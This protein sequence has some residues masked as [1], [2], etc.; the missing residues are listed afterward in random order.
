M[1]KPRPFIFP[2]FAILMLSSTLLITLLFLLTNGLQAAPNAIW[3]VNTFTG[4][5]GFDCTTSG[6]ACQTI[7]AAVDKAGNGDTIQIATGTYSEN[8]IWI[9]ET[10]TLNGAGVGNTIVDGGGNGRIFRISNETTLSGMTI[11]NGN[12]ITVGAIF[13][14]GGGAIQT[15]N[16]LTIQNSRIISNGTVG[17]GGGIFNSGTLILDNTDVLS[18]SSGLSG[19]GIYNSFLGS[20]TITNSVVGWN[21]SNSNPA[22]GGIYTTRPLYLTDVTLRDNRAPA[23][24]GGGLYLGDSGVA[25]DVI[26]TNVTFMGNQAN[27][28]A[29][30]SAQRGTITM[31]SGTVSG[32]VA[33][34][35]RGGIHLTGVDTSLNLINSTVVNNR[36]TGTTSAGYNGVYAV[37]GATATVSNSIIANNAENN[38]NSD[39]NFVSGGYNLADDDSCPFGEAGDQQNVNPLLGSLADNGGA[40]LTHALLPNSPAIDAGTN[41]NCPASDQRGITR[42]FDGDNSGTATCD[43]GA[44]EAQNQLVIAD[45]SLTEGNSGT[46]TAVFTVTLSPTSTQTVNVNYATVNGTASNASD[47]DPAT[48]TLTFNPNETTQFVNVTVNGDMDDELDETF[49]VQLDTPVNAEIV[50]GQATGTIIDDD[51]LPTLLISD[52]T[53]LEGSF[54]TVDAVFTV[55]LSPPTTDVVTVDYVSNNDTAVAPSDYTAVNDT[56]TFQPSETSKT[57]TVTVPADDIDE[58]VSERFTIDLSNA[59]NA[60]IGD[61]QGEGIITD[62]DTAQMT[63][64]NGPT[65]LE[66]SSGLT[67]AVFTVTLS[68]PAAFVVTVDYVANSGFGV[69]GAQE[70]SDFVATSGTLTFQPGETEKTYTVPIVTDTNREEDETFTT[71][72]SNG[73]VPILT[74]VSIGRIINDDDNYKLYLPMI[75]R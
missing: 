55:T 59:S 42:P 24:S 9:T 44:Y 67:P 17:S 41:V 29:A 16:M 7:T 8:N 34:S 13:D 56:L 47:F 31:R 27:N 4:N 53:V 63:H 28:G 54:G 22:G 2:L 11:Q 1:L 43:I 60:N 66:G 18:N 10:L 61:P 38:C 72:I 64:V 20:I 62:D 39:P 74:N 23:G 37:S 65:V 49:F 45:V 33:S 52:Q 35:N 32:N 69:M 6:T 15:N 14:M 26:L 5:N 3:Y 12:I 51:G 36:R 73:N 46:T 25:Y 75:I 57:I 71:V 48:G 21:T 30:L 50:D 19:G 58:G 70:G 68:T 40:T